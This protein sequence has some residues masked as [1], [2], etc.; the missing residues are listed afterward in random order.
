M[1]LKH[2][3]LIQCPLDQV[4]KDTFPILPWVFPLSSQSL[5]STT[6]CHLSQLSHLTTH[7]CTMWDY[8]PMMSSPSIGLVI[9][10]FTVEHIPWVEHNIPIPPGLYNEVIRIIKEKIKVG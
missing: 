8:L 10:L 1:N 3:S 4:L 6:P 9:T 5:A 2:T 7:P